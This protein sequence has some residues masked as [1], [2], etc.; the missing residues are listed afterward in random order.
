MAMKISQ[1]FFIIILWFSI[2]L[3]LFHTCS[4]NSIIYINHI[5]VDSKYNLNN[6]K[7]LASNFDFSP[8]LKHRHNGHD[9]RHSPE[10][11]GEEID[12]RFGVEKRLVPT[13][14]NPLHH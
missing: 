4:K 7:L 9:R 6:R 12:P 11:A 2:F 14:P 13:G 10:T 5:S 1:Y 3:L 8:F